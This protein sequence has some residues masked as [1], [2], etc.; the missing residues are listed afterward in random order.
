MVDDFSIDHVTT[1]NPCGGGG[2]NRK[3][4]SNTLASPLLC[5]N[6]AV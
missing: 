4:L 3:K 1:P 5:N 6:D 2:I